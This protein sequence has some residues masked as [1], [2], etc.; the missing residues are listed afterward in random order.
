MINNIAEKITTVELIK[1]A[2]CS[3]VTKSRAIYAFNYNV[4]VVLS[5]A[6]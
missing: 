5:L 1:K 2:Y 4:S 3:T 6:V